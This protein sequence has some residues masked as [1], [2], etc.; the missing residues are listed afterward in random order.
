MNLDSLNGLVAI[1]PT[2]FTDDGKIDENFK[3]RFLKK[4]ISAS[5]NLP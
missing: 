2:P 5:D 1:L 3:D 4:N